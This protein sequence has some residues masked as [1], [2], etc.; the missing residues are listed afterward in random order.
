VSGAE[1]VLDLLAA[2]GLRWPAPVEA[3]AT[4]SSTNDRL[5]ELARGGAP[6][7]TAVMADRQTAGRGRQGR[8]W[9]S[10]EGDLFLSVLLRPTPAA[11]GV[12]L[13]PLAAGI[14]VHEALAGLGVDGRLKWPNDVLVGGRKIAGILCEAATGGSGIESVVVGIGVNVAAPPDALPA[15]VRAVAVSVRA[16][17]AR[18][19]APAEVAAEVLA[20]LPLWY[21]EPASGRALLEAW[22]TRSVPWWGRPV[23]VRAAGSVLRGRVRGLAEDGGLE[24]D[25]DDGGV[26]TVRSGDVSELRL[27]E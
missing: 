13:V 26:A 15:D 22:R 25:L 20:R 10:G 18:D 8:A 6:E 7:W 23:E 4:V 2:K 1:R 17:L 24:L 5:R 11:A 27:A 19:I 12:G 21:H 14:A 9:V 3:L 16:L